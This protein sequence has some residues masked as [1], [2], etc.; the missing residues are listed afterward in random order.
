MVT[1]LRGNLRI[2]DFCF[3][4]CIHILIH[5]GLVKKAVD[6]SASRTGDDLF[7]GFNP[8]SVGYGVIPRKTFHESP[9]LILVNI[10]AVSPPPQ[11][12]GTSVK[13]NG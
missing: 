12:R 13:K 6:I 5:F 11:K 3:A 10:M 4:C 8:P 2:R 7:K 9:L 1:Y